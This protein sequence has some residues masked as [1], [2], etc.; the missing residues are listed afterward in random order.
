MD[1]NKFTIRKTD[2]MPLGASY[3]DNGIRFAT[4]GDPKKN[5]GVVL[6]PENASEPIKIPFPEETKVGRVCAMEVLGVPNCNKYLFFSDDETYLDPYM[7]ASC[8]FGEFGV[9]TSPFSLVYKDEYVDKNDHVH[10]PFNESIFYMLHVRG[11]TAHNSSKTKYKGTFKGVMNKLPYLE[12]LGVTS[13]IFMPIY[14]FNENI[15]EEK[16]TY[17]SMQTAVQNSFDAP[18]ESV[19]ENIRDLGRFVNT[20]SAKKNKVNFWGYTDAYYYVPKQSF[21]ASE[22]SVKEFHELVDKIHE[23]GMEVILQFKFPNNFSSIQIIDVLRFWGLQYK[24]DGFQLIGGDLPIGDILADPYLYKLK[25]LYDNNVY[26]DGYNVNPEHGFIDMGFLVDARCFLKGDPNK[27]EDISKRFRDANPHKHVI[28]AIARQDSMRLYDIV[29][30]NEKHNMENGENGRDG[31]DNNFSWNCGIEGPTKKK[32]VNAL[33]IKQV[34]NALTFVFMSQGSPLLYSGDE[35]L[36]TQFGNNNPYNQDNEISYIKWSDS[37]ASKEILK[38]TKTLI[39]IRKNHPSLCSDHA[40]SGRDQ[41]SYGYPDVSLHGSS[42]WR[43]DLSPSS[44]TFGMLYFDKYF[45]DKDNRLVYII[46][47]MHWEKQ[48]VAL[49][50]LSKGNSFCMALSTDSL[51]ELANEDSIVLEPRSCVILETTNL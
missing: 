35:F 27:C 38:F 39:Q 6:F 5:V 42:L 2:M 10:I 48:K 41:L 29:S 7:R 44:H 26:L 12:N 17:S 43:P 25:I 14:E 47:N 37:K 19:P 33:R 22:D 24:V 20:T 40:L 28:N 31:A 16:K 21:S 1:Q 15:A 36:N 13:L 11:F 32:S 51:N 9:K 49:P 34:K 3:T 4:I 46:F 50:K 8:G 23:K 30:Y 18:H 45:D